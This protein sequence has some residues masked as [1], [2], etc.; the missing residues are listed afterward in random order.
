MRDI[1]FFRISAIVVSRSVVQHQFAAAIPRDGRDGHVVG[2]R[3]QP[4]AGDDQV[5]TFVGHEPQLRFD[6]GGTVTA[7][8]DVR[9]FDAELQQPIGQPGTVAVGDPAGQNLGAGDDDSRACAHRY[10]I[11]R[12]ASSGF[13]GPRGQVAFH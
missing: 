12:A 5:Y 7:D 13:P 2:G 6:V 10:D 3:S 9:E 1:N 11:R 4:A 8:G